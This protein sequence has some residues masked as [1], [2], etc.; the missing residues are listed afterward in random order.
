MIAFDIAAISSDAIIKNNKKSIEEKK[1]LQATF[2]SF[3][4]PLLRNAYK[5]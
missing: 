4:S 2:N 3:P 5:N 1:L